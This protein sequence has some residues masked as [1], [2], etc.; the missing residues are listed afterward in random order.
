MIN[1]A[2]G[3]FGLLEASFEDHFIGTVRN[4]IP[5]IFLGVGLLSLFFDFNY[6]N[7]TNFILIVISAFVVSIILWSIKLWGG[8]DAKLYIGLMAMHY[9]NPLSILASFI[10]GIIISGIYNDLNKNSLKISRLGLFILI[11]YT[12]VTTFLVLSAFG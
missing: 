11:G 5:L 6:K 8:G 4:R 9:Q 7:L 3:L 1:Y 12:L 10:I 2:I